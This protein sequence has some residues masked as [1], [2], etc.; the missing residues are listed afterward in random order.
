[1]SDA[2]LT[3]SAEDARKEA[4]AEC[5]E[6]ER[7]PGT[8]SGFKC[9]AHR[10]R[11]SLSRP[12]VASVRVASQRFHLG[13]FV[14]AEAAAL[15]YARFQ[16]M[17]TNLLQG[18]VNGSSQQSGAVAS[19]SEAGS[20]HA[21]DLQGGVERGCTH[22]SGE[23]RGE[24]A[25]TV[26]AAGVSASKRPRDLIALGATSSERECTKRV[27]SLGESSTASSG[28]DPSGSAFTQSA[29]PPSA[30]LP[31]ALPTSALPASALPTSTLARGVK[32][33]L[34][35]EAASCQTQRAA[36][37][38]GSSEEVSPPVTPPGTPP[39]SSSTPTPHP[40]CMS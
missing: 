22:E 3:L 8:A 31:S 29:L 38:G 39:H 35:D 26:S 36:G 18:I 21:L 2:E 5:I 4:I 19:A 11:I 10:P 7:A 25:P 27:R 1:V 33:R 12:Y 20:T 15:A 24:D 37:D 28:L 6:L 17:T 16:K 9:V 13:N 32:R 34:R 14:T 30:L 23:A 40:G